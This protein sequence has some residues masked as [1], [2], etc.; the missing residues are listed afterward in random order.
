M[1]RS[2]AYASVLSYLLMPLAIGCSMG[3][4]LNLNAPGGSDGTGQTQIPDP[5][6]PVTTGG[7]PPPPGGA[8]YVVQLPFDYLHSPS[9]ILEFAKGSSGN[10]KPISEITGPAGV[11]FNEIAVD[12]AGDL[13]VQG[14]RDSDY[15]FDVYIYPAGASGIATPSGVITATNA[16]A[17]CLDSAGKLYTIGNGLNYGIRVYDPTTPAAPP[18]RTIPLPQQLNSVH[19]MTVDSSGNIYLLNLGM[20]QNSAVVVLS[21]TGSS[22]SLLANI[23][24]PATGLSNPTG[25]AVDSTGNMYVGAYDPTMRTG[26]ILVFAPGANGDASPVRTIVGS[27]TQLGP[28]QGIRVDK[29]G[30]VY[31]TAASVPGLPQHILTFAAGASGDVAPLSDLAPATS[32]V[33]HMAEN[34][35]Q[36]A[37]L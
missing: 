26:R 18:L 32:P 16:S 31:V 19:N 23:S 13:L 35:G 29:A 3:P 22:A 21:T 24:G 27:K 14:V 7:Q 33:N 20:A 36:L 25:I 2:S 30:T 15:A 28:I 12:A 8:L 4:S 6:Q 5:F 9:Y 37:V 10:E 11:Y 17:L 1:K 34:F